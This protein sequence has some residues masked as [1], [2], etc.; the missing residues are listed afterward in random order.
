MNGHTALVRML[1]RI[2]TNPE[3]GLDVF[4]LLKPLCR[5]LDL[6]RKL[7]YLDYGLSVTEY[8]EKL[9]SEDRYLEQLKE[10]LKIVT[11]KNGEKELQWVQ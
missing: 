8:L 9:I 4:H 3:L 7:P 1:K 11:L 10:W 6:K 5:G 2:D